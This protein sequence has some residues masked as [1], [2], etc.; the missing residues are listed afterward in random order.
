M[1]SKDKTNT[2]VERILRFEGQ[3]G[4]SIE[5][6][7]EYLLT[8]SNSTVPKNETINRFFAFTINNFSFRLTLR[9]QPI[10]YLEDIRNN[11]FYLVQCF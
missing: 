1:N 10:L 11:M 8:I 9:I 7:S 3:I 4:N 2:L 5:L 6:Q